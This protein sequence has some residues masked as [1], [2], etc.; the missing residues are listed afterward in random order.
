MISDLSSNAVGGAGSTG[1]C[2]QTRALSA[3]PCTP[4]DKPMS[5]LFREPELPGL[6][7]A[8][9]R[10]VP[11]GIRP[12]TPMSA[13]PGTCRGGNAAITRASEPQHPIGLAPRPPG[14]ICWKKNPPIV[15]R[16]LARSRALAEPREKVGGDQVKAHALD[17]RTQRKLRE[18]PMARSRWL[19]RAVISATAARSNR[20]TSSH[21]RPSPIPA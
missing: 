15:I 18:T 5:F 6:L 13:S 20:A 16:A 19:A 12:W 11:R 14:R 21:S 9:P 2:W 17:G 8:E 4:V 1:R 7:L 10:G 3:A